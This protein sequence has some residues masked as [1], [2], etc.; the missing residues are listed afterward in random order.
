MKFI[1]IIAAILIPSIGNAVTVN[2]ASMVTADSA[3]TPL[4][5]PYRDANGG[6]SAGALVFQLQVLTTAQLQARTDTPYTLYLSSEAN[7]TGAGTGL[8]VSTAAAIGSYI[9][10]STVTTTNIGKACGQ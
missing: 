7:Q 10:L 8:C 5:I 9:Y 3:N 4:T 1:A 2:P 6:F